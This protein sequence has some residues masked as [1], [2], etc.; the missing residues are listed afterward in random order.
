MKCLTLDTTT[1]TCS[2]AVADETGLLAEYNFAHRMDL[3]RRLM[4]NIVSLLAD[5][6]LSLPQ[7]ELIGVSVGPGSFTGL[8]IGIVTAKTLA[9][10]LGIPIAP[11]VGLDALAHAFDYLPNWTVCP[12]VKVRKGEVY[13]ALYRSHSGG[14]ARTSDYSVGSVEEVIRQVE[15]EA[16]FCGDAVAENAEAL[17]TVGTISPAS[18]PRAS[19]IARL[20]VEKAA[21]GETMDALSVLPFYMRKSTPEIR[22]EST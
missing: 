19:I 11:V 4:P 1:G 2:I 7:I 10:V 20:A 18:Y 17:R 3:S 8:R 13:Y 16:I 15:G 22:L 14:L 5:C 21:S 12:M 6:S 9:Q